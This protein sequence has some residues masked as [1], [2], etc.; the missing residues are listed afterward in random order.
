[1][2]AR[3]TAICVRVSL[4]IPPHVDIDEPPERAMSLLSSLIF[5][6]I[7]GCTIAI[8]TSSSWHHRDVLGLSTL[9]RPVIQTKR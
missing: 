7:T 1:M 8:S 3:T 2:K 9:H 5:I 4:I 6:V